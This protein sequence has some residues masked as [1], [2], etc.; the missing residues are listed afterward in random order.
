MNHKRILGLCVLFFASGFSALCLQTTWNRIL[1]QLIGIDYASQIVVTS[2]FMLG[3]GLGAALGGWITRVTRHSLFFFALAEVAIALFAVFSDMLLRSAQPVVGVLSQGLLG[4]SGLLWDFLVYSAILLLP[5]ILMGSSL[6]IVVHALRRRLSA[7]V[8][9]GYFYTIN[10]VGAIVGCFASSMFLTAAFGLKGTLLTAAII[11]ML[12]AL[13]FIIILLDGKAH[14]IEEE[15]QP[16]HNN[17]RPQAPSKVKLLS[18]MI[19]VVALG[20]EVFYFRILTFF[21]GATSYVFPIALGCFLIHIAIGSYLA[22]RWLQ[23][24]LTPGRVIMY[25][26]LGTICFIFLPFI[27]AQVLGLVSSAYGIAALYVS[28]QS[29]FGHL[30]LCLLITFIFMISISFLS[31]VFPAIIACYC[32]DRQRTGSGVG[33]IYF[34]QTLGNFAGALIVGGI[35]IPTFGILV[36]IHLLASLLFVAA[37]L[38]V[39]PG[40]P[41]AGCLG[42]LK[43][44]RIKGAFLSLVLI[45]IL[46]A[47]PL[48]YRTIR[49]KHEPPVRVENEHEGVVLSHPS[50]HSGR[51]AGYRLNV[52]AESATGYNVDNRDWK[53]NVWPLSG[54]VAALGRAPKSALVIGIG[55]GDL[56][57]D[58]KRYFPDIEITI[59]ELLDTVIKEMKT[60]GSEE[61]RSLIRKS[62]VHVM[63][64]ARFINRMN[65]S[66]SRKSYDIIQIGVFHVTASGAGNLFTREFIVTLKQFLAPDGVLTFNAYAPVVKA[67]H[68]LFSTSWIASHGPLTVSDVFLSKAAWKTGG[69]DFQSALDQRY[70]Q[71]WSMLCEVRRKAGLDN[72]APVTPPPTTFLISDAAK[73][74]TLLSKIEPQTNDRI[75]TEHFLYWDGALRPKWDPRFYDV[76]DADR[77][78]EDLARL[79]HATN[80]A[81]DK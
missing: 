34:I 50:Y 66:P 69:G 37:L 62:D 38:W 81:N 9:T 43:N 7:G 70:Q 65:Y 75:V 18:F 59:V 60:Y 49:Y 41:V 52:G 19:G 42:Y 44:S 1:S 64:G 61:L 26:L 71:A 14:E 76:N 28:G 72:C 51:I 63:D 45:G 54:V 55:T 12:A 6:P 21:F 73:I 56:V 11:N 29:G 16:E 23:E 31:T 39:Y 68:S 36:S 74:E 47:S 10:V 80:L 20:L 25:G 13:G 30:L 58:L 35:I 5:I 2:I 3:L 40:S 33:K 17:S 46:S 32:N 4:M 27:L 8:A 15:S 78:G 48:F 24:G 22:G 79:W 67:V 53:G 77:T 57:I